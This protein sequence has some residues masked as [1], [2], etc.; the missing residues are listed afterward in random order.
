MQVGLQKSEE[1]L[2]FVTRAS[3]DAFVWD[4]DLSTDK[5]R[6]NKAVQTLFGYSPDE[7]GSDIS[8]WVEHIHPED[9][10]RVVSGIH[11]AVDKGECTWSD[12]YR[13]CCKDN[14]YAMTLDRGFI[15]HDDTGKAVN[16]IS[17]MMDITK[18]K[19][20][21]QENKTLKQQIEFI[22]G[23]TKTGLDIIDSEY[24]ILYIDPEWQKIYGDP[25]GR[26][27]YEY[28]MGRNEICPGCGLVKAFETK[29][30]TVTEEILV[31]ENNRPVQ[32]TTIP[33]QNDR[34]EWLV[35]EVNVDI[36]ERKIAEEALESLNQQMKATI[37]K[38][39]T[40]N[41]ELADF[42]H[43]VAHDLKSPLRAVGSLAGIIWQ[44]YSDKLGEEGKRQLDLIVGR[45][46]R[47]Y[48]LINGILR[49]SEL[50]RAAAG[51]QRVDLN[52]V[53]AEAIAEVAPPEN[54]EIIV[55]NQL[56]TLICDETRMIQVFQNLISNAVEYM[57]KP[58]GLIKIGCVEEN[59]FWKFGV[60]D[61]G[62]GI[63]EKYFEKIFEIFQTLAP[64]D[65]LENVGIGLSIVKKIVELY[66][67]KVWVESEV[68]QYSTF[69]FTLLKQK[70]G[71]ERAKFKADIAY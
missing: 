17:L 55:E 60:S 47:M 41:R 31:K 21:D 65:K 23:A 43:V 4:W 2:Q 13:F 54:I 32:V 34:G 12:E 22:L 52:R 45:I 70:K 53:V 6:W 5:L 57:N 19:I 46:N 67:G 50:G 18:R 15:I 9:R 71:A 42:A 66:G 40:A 29:A 1:Q 3:S 62:P 59:G 30:I 64:R 33:Y 7:I 27:C 11:A 36:T 26:K 49:Y 69:Y 39:T 68:G 38:L 63:E 16:I 10:Q 14:S 48:G 44:D 25:A 37:K 28:F 20:A 61:N 24:N 35:A 58:Q 56:P 8:W 51:K